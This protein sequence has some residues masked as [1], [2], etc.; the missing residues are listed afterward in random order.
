M[1]DLLDEIKEDLHEERIQQLWKNYGSW[2]VGG[3]VA[4]LGS[5]ALGV[6]WQSWSASKQSDYASTYANA[7]TIES[8]RLEESLKLLE[9][10]SHRS[11]GF[12]LLAKF[13]LASHALKAGDRAQAKS[14]LH[15][16]GKMGH[17]D[18]LYR[19]LA[20]L[21]SLYIGLDTLEANE[22]LKELETLTGEKNPWRYLALELKGL[23]L[24]KKKDYALAQATFDSLVALN[25]PIPAFS[26]RVK[27][28]AA[29]A[30]ASH[31]T[32]QVAPPPPKP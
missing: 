22:G 9:D 13:H 19:D 6:A 1:S 5:T 27:A 21:M 25:L 12:A 28:L 3:V 2:L 4:I 18:P 15:E 17:L 11:T 26:H 23:L 29:W 7:L 16:V 10:L 8:E 32:G 30:K 14:H 20:K 24:L 31:P